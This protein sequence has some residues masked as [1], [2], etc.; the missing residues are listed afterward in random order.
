[1][2][3][4]SFG[5][6]FYRR[7]YLDARTQVTTRAEMAARARLIA[8]LVR[9]V[10]LPVRTILDAGCGLGW[11][12]RP[13]LREFPRASYT[14]IEISR[15]ICERYGWTHAS[16]ATYRTRARFDLIVCYDVLQYLTDAEAARAVANLGRLCRGALF[17]HAPT[18]ED[19]THNADRSCSDEDIHL[20]PTAWYRA[21]LARRFR[22]A[23]FGLYV[24]RGAPVVE[25]ELARVE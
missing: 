10:D 13:L 21:R 6:E 4:H 24:R 16:I 5:P 2:P 20:R 12:R 17:L 22:N 11:M 8:S 25:W 1:M 7:F 9:S 14:G 15:H 19:W 18:R 23:G 3:R